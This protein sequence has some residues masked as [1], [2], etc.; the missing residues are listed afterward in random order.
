MANAGL[1]FKDR[2]ERASNFS[3]WRERIGLLLEEHGLWEFV[4]GTIVLLFDLA[5]QPSHL[6]KDVKARRIIV[7]AVKY[8]IIPHIFVK[9]K[10]KF[11]WEALDK[12]YQ[13]DNQSRKM[14]LRDKL[15]S[16]KMA[17]GES[18]VTYLTKLTQIRD[19]LEDVWDNMDETGW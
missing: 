7:D 11:M 8:Q 1:R 9:N 13:S 16:T 18:I 2:I 12:L 14:L 19:K 5:Q 6:K 10:N 15:R 17:R 4:E 3:P